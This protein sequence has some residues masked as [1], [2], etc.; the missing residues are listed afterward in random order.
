[1]Q[2]EFNLLQVSVLGVFLICFSCGLLMFLLHRR[3]IWILM[4]QILSL[5]SLIGMVLYLTKISTGSRDLSYFSLILLILL[6]FLL[7]YGVLVIQ[8]AKRTVGTSD[9]DDEVYLKD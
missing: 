9:W 1:M 7:A 2:S 6:P 4:G 3:A 8:T 5:K